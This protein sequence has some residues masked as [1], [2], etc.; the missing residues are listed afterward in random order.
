[1]NIGIIGC[2][3]ISSVYFNAHHLYNNFKV[4]I[5]WERRGLIKDKRLK[6]CFFIPHIRYCICIRSVPVY[7]VLHIVLVLRTTLQYCTCTSQCVQYR[8][9][10]TTL[11]P[12]TSV[13]LT[14]TSAPGTSTLKKL[15]KNR[16]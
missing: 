1:M 7:Y 5:N 2:G 3:N 9:P 16:S 11:V 10:C 4:I 8:Y 6:N 14:T 12:H 15:E 13:L